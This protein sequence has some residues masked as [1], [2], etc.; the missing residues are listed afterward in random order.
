MP[1][2]MI[3]LLLTGVI[4]T[5]S[6]ATELQR[7]AERPTSQ[8]GKPNTKSFLKR[9]FIWPAS[10]NNAVEFDYF[11]DSEFGHDFLR[12]FVNDVIVFSSSG[13][14]K[15]GTRR[16]SIPPTGGP[17]T[18]KFEY[19]K[20][21]S[22]DRGFD[23]AWVDNIKF[24]GFDATLE[25]QRFNRQDFPPLWLT[26]GSG[27]GW[28]P[29]GWELSSPYSERSAGRPV[30]QSFLE[31]RFAP[32]TGNGCD[33]GSDCPSA[34]TCFSV[35]GTCSRVATRSW[36]ERTYFWA[37]LVCTPSCEW[38]AAVAFDYFVDTEQGHDFLNM[39]IDGSLVNLAGTQPPRGISGRNRRGHKAVRIPTP[40]KHTIRFEYAK[41]DA[42]DEGL[43][44]VR[45]DRITFVSSSGDRIEERHE[46]DGRNLQKKP[47]KV[48]KCIDESWPPNTGSNTRCVE[49]ITGGEGGGWTIF[50]ASPSKSYVPLQTSGISLRPGFAK[51]REPL[52]DG[53]LQ[54][55]YLN[56]TIMR[57]LAYGGA[58]QPPATLMMTA[59]LETSALNLGLRTAAATPQQVG[60]ESG[61]LTLYL[62]VNHLET[63]RHSPTICSGRPHLPDRDD[64][65]VRITYSIA[66]DMVTVSVV[67]FRG[68][69]E[70]GANAWTPLAS[71]SPWGVQAALSEPASDKGQLHLEVKITLPQSVF[72]STKPMIGLALKRLNTFAGISQVERLPLVDNREGFVEDDVY[73]WESIQL[74]DERGAFSRTENPNDRCCFPQPS[75]P[76]V[77]W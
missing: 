12:V 58:N 71:E 38:T 9:T 3:L 68:T 13:L 40:G 66:G 19:A 31:E 24:L 69:C 14:N 20:N 47:I 61:T 15:S 74:Y 51:Y 70:P 56:P 50:N 28:A 2:L 41:D 67:Q 10:P 1:C 72:A 52:T 37:P 34:S 45:V 6:V 16:V 29:V 39:Y 18:L 57:L 59:S 75:R 73:T 23:T 4:V 26:G 44:Q 63:L 8:I 64:R 5:D 30:E 62:D 22:L 27:T 55:E 7:R 54:A 53:I 77:N 33:D 43:D 48:G 25:V 21:G 49:W 76:N 46:F 32:Q 36:M 60:N 35:L 11:V 42:G 65:R 17:I